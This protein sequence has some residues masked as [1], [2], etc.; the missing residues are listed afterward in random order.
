MELDEEILS[1]KIDLAILQFKAKNYEKCVSIYTELVSQLRSL[2][3]ARV[4]KTRRYHQLS[5]RPVY[6]KLV[7]PR[8]CGILDQRAATFEKLNDLLQARQDAQRIISLDPVNCKG[9]LRLGKI[10]MKENNKISA[11]KI[12][13][14]GVYVI[15]KALEQKNFDAPERLWKQLS[16]QYRDLNRTLKMERSANKSLSRAPSS[17]ASTES[18][19]VS[20]H[21]RPIHSSSSR[22]LQAQL[23]KMLPLKRVASEPAEPQKRSKSPRDIFQVFPKEVIEIIYTNLP[24]RDVLKSL[25]VCRAWYDA[26]TT[27]PSLYRNNFTLKHRVTS[28][29]YFHGLKLMKKVSNHSFSRS[30]GKLAVSSA[31]NLQHLSRIL[32]SIISDTSLR[33]SRLH[34]V[35]KNLSMELIMQKLEKLEWDYSGLSSV[36]HL[37]L[38]FNSSIYIG[39]AL[40]EIFPK[41][42]SMEI[43]NVDAIPRKSNMSMIPSFSD[44]YHAFVARS[45][46]IQTQ[47]TL[48]KLLLTNH[49]LLKRDSQSARPGRKTFDPS[50]LFLNISFPC[51]EEW[52]VTSYDFTNS[53]AT[54]QAFWRNTPFLTDIYLENNDELSIRKFLFLLASCSPK[55]RLKRLTLR[56]H[57]QE[58]VYNIDEVLPD[59]LDC[60][61]ALSHLD[62]YGSSISGTGFL[63]LL[64]IANKEGRMQSL[65]IGHSSYIQFKNDSFVSGN[66]VLKFSQLFRIAPDLHTLQVP[67][68]DLDNLS[69]KLLGEDLAQSYSAIGPRVPLKHLD[70]SFCNSIDGIG[71]MNL[72]GAGSRDPASQLSLETLI[73]DG[74]HFNPQTLQLLQRKGH[75]KTLQNDPFKRKWRNYGFNSFLLETD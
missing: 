41:L 14:Q 75:V 19:T 4:I 32:E 25:L 8:L 22:G 33:I 3:E 28:P 23:D 10:H 37:R 40:F 20:F 49:P 45:Q 42:E 72:F 9:Y 69:M 5:D 52:R 66:T 26:L 38:G 44:R 67:E 39:T 50:P 61:H 68:L 12:Y 47:E 58:G 15:Q 56:E 70:V 30:V 51:L 43:L 62:I 21:F 36:R 59:N 73:I 71:L 60:L 57:H 48:K 7:H 29:E 64:T 54:L 65:N 46:S 13:Q 6:G 2:S 53:A 24:F 17:D 11:Y 63:K 1:D 18:P 35:D 74:L 55:F 16:T 27:I 31:F 34:L